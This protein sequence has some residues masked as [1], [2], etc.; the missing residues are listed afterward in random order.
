[1]KKTENRIEKV[2]TK[3]ITGEVYRR[4]ID[5]GNDVEFITGVRDEENNYLSEILD[6][7][8]DKNVKITIEDILMREQKINICISSEINTYGERMVNYDALTDEQ[9]DEQLKYFEY[10]VEEITGKV[11]RREIDYGN[12]VEY[13]TVIEDE[14]NNTLSE[15]L[16]GYANKKVKITIEIVE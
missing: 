10:P 3:E 16:E 15:I 5:Y 2:E 11:K 14:E 6:D 1:M 12:D 7:L 8:I 4:E 9:L 13:I